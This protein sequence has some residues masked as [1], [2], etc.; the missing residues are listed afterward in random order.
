MVGCKGWLAAA[1]A[2]VFVV[3][4][5]AVVADAEA[6]TARQRSEAEAAAHGAAVSR[7]LM[8]GGA[9][10]G[11]AAATTSGGTGAMSSGSMAGGSMAAGP[12]LTSRKDIMAAQRALNSAGAKLKVD[13]KMGPNTRRALMN[14]QAQNGMTV[15]GQLDS[16]TASRLG[17]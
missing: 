4:S 15:T 12:A 7:P 2:S 14:Y 10:A 13:G 5:L 11:G 17:I 3:G 1:A 16:A 8:G 6:S 9:A